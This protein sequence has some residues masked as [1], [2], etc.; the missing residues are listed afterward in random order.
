MRPQPRY[1]PA[2]PCDHY[3]VGCKRVQ[4]SLHVPSPTCES[5]HPPPTAHCRPLSL[6]PTLDTHAIIEA[7][8]LV[9]WAWGGSRVVWVLR[10]GVCVSLEGSPPS[11]QRLPGFSNRALACKVATASAIPLPRC[12]ARPI[13]QLGTGCK[14]DAHNS[15][16]I[17]CQSFAWGVTVPCRILKLWH[18]VTAT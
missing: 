1:A 18:G 12:L 6:P 17:L 11:C 14:Q 8:P 7:G 2:N 10:A 13:A 4:N 15:V 9:Q 16:K 5:G 3:L